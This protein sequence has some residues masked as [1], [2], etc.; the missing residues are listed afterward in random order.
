M[1]FRKMHFFDEI[2]VMTNNNKHT[3]K[4]TKPF[5]EFLQNLQIKV[6]CRFV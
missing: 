4:F 2:T 6:V 5:F 1:N 3:G